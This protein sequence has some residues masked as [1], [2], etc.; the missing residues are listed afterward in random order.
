MDKYNV[1]LLLKSTT[2]KKEVF[3]PTLLYRR[4]NYTFKILN[5]LIN[6]IIQF[7]ISTFKFAFSKLESE[8]FHLFSVTLF[9]RFQSMKTHC[10]SVKSY[11]SF[12]TFDCLLLKTSETFQRFPVAFHWLK[13]REQRFTENQ[14]ILITY[15]S[16][17]FNIVSRIV[18]L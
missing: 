14:H 10:Q 13:S 1:R 17:L 15:V 7:L 4:Y 9:S 2:R 6:W 3:R 18:C 8:E 16:K 11:W 12:L 5:I